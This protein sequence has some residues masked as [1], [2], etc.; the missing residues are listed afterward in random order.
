M[1]F[2]Y[3]NNMDRKWMNFGC[4]AA[5]VAGKARLEGYR[6]AFCGKK[7]NEGEATILPEK[8]RYVD[9]VLWRLTEECEAT[10]DRYKRCPFWYKKELVRVKAENGRTYETIAYVMNAPFKDRL[11][12]PSEFRLSV[13]LEGCR[14]NGIPTEPIMEA[15]R[16]SQLEAGVKDA[17]NRE[18]GRER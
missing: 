13:I 4:P 18:K 15:A 7:M 8:G 5:E 14:Q 1:F 12:T 17:G 2:A 16:Q 11:A 3:S 10:L 6:L 9:G